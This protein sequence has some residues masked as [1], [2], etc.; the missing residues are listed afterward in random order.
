M[1]PTLYLPQLQMEEPPFVP[2][3]DTCDEI[4]PQ[5]PVEATLY[6]DY[7][8]K[9]PIIFFVVA[10]ALLLAYQIWFG[11]KSRAWG[12]FI[13]LGVGTA[14]ELAGYAARLKMIDN[15][16]EDGPFQLQ[17]LLLILGP[18][19]IA[20]A[21]A[22]TFKHV[23]L[24]Y[25]P[26]LSVLRPRWYPFVFV[27]TDIVAILVQGAGAV[28]AGAENGNMD[29]SSGLLIGGVSFQL[30]NMIG[31]GLIMVVYWRRYR[32]WKNT[33]TRTRREEEILEAVRTGNTEYRKVRWFVRF[34]VVAYVCII[35]RC[36]YR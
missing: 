33:S 30:V 21:I 27:G 28:M 5:C 25:G 18:T 3:Y 7:F 34:I 35:V 26:E 24:Y 1:S 14:F 16:W 4:T 13:W 6:G 10:Y 32:S 15:P 9:G 8:T 17:L 22:V 23:V 29:A 12:F 31:C 36:I 19:L 2:G 11:F 20:A